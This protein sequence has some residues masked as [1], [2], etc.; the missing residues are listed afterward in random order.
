MIA[1]MIL[2]SVHVNVINVEPCDLTAGKMTTE[3][4][5]LQM[6]HITLTTPKTLSAFPLMSYLA[7]YPSSQIRY[8][9]LPLPS[10]HM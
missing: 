9:I 10:P 8:L 3:K 4:S 6:E 7:V 5:H 1:I 2:I